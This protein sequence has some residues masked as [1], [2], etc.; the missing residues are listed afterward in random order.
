MK[1][2][3]IFMVQSSIFIKLYEINKFCYLD[4]KKA[5]PSAVHP[6]INMEEVE[7]GLYFI[8]NRKLKVAMSVPESKSGKLNPSPDVELSLF[9]WK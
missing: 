6:A 2:G 1:V 9:S 5:S 3:L 4:N 8:H 7:L